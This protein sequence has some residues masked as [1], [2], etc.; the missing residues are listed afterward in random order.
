MNVYTYVQSAFATGKRSSQ[1]E[2][3][4]CKSTRRAEM[5]SDQHLSPNQTK[6]ANTRIF[7]RNKKISAPHRRCTCSSNSSGKGVREK[8]LV[9]VIWIVK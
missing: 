3:R 7:G 4:H 6:Y 8:L 1:D 2:G 5:F 9:K